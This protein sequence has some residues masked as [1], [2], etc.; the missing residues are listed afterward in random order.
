MINLTRGYSG[1]ETKEEED[2]AWKKIAKNLVSVE[3][4]STTADVWLI[5]CAE[6]GDA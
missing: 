6:G 3:D 4:D 2:R 5:V 1:K